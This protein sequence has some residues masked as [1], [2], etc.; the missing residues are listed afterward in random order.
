MR[1]AWTYI[2]AR[3]SQVIWFLWG[4]WEAE[5]DGHPE[6]WEFALGWLIGLAILSILARFI[7]RMFK[8]SETQWRESVRRL[9]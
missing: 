7:Y 4:F 8:R 3:V 5:F 9:P 1:W 2:A 6:S